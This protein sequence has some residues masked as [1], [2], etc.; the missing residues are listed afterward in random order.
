M[1]IFVI[2]CGVFFIL[3]LIMDLIMMIPLTTMELE[4]FVEF[5]WNSYKSIIGSIVYAINFWFLLL[6]VI[7]IQPLQP[8]AANLC[9]YCYV[10]FNE[11]KSMS[12]IGSFLSCFKSDLNCSLCIQLG[13]NLYSTVTI[14]WILLQIWFLWCMSLFLVFV[15]LNHIYL[16]CTS[17]PLAKLML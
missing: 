13:L 2:H 6:Y 16:S 4:L 9:C 3:I 5:P 14:G 15:I 11:I 17:M 1:L 7:W 10:M 12:L 8:T